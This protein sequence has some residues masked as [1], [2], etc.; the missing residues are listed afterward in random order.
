MHAKTHDF[1]LILYILYFANVFFLNNFIY[2]IL[3]F[4]LRNFYF[5][6]FCFLLLYVMPSSIY[7]HSVL[8]IQHSPPPRPPPPE[9]PKSPPKWPL[10]PGVM[11]HV[12][13]DTKQN[14]CASRIQKPSSIPDTPNTAATNS[15]TGQQPNEQHNISNVS[16][17]SPILNK[18]PT[19]GVD[20]FVQM[21]M[22]AKDN[23]AIVSATNASSE[24]SIQPPPVLPARNML[25]KF[26]TSCASAPTKTSC[27]RLT[28]EEN[29][30]DENCNNTTME[31]T[32][33]VPN[34]PGNNDE[35][36]TFTSSSLI[37]KI[38]SRLRWRRERTKHSSSTGN[39]GASNSD[40]CSSSNGAGDGTSILSKSNRRAAVSL[41]RGTGWFGSGKSTNSSTG[42]FDKDHHLNGITCDDGGKVL[43]FFAESFFIIF[44]FQC[45]SFYNHHNICFASIHIFHL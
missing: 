11:V 12:K 44:F 21:Q 7:I 10:R 9:I 22:D 42:L 38:L 30:T 40:N 17:A 39:C 45:S 13:V 23:V 2:S 28:R 19:T 20:T 32:T 24:L 31:Q 6:S 35:L 14:L 1:T 26:A 43:L 8:S 34:A 25:G 33:L 5:C 27:T 37:E 41:L 16:Y 15:V 4:M 3:T 29:R 18:T 36:I